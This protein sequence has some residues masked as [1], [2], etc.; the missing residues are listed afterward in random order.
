MQKRLT[1][2]KTC[3]GAAM[4]ILIADAMSGEA[5]DILSMSS[6]ALRMVASSFWGSGMEMICAARGRV[7]LSDL[8][9]T[10]GSW[11]LRDRF[12]PANRFSRRPMQ[13]TL[14]E[15]LDD[16][17]STE[18]FV[19]SQTTH[20]LSFLFHPV[21]PGE[22]CSKTENWLRPRE[23]SPAKALGSGASNRVEY[24]ARE[25]LSWLT[26]LYPSHESSTGRPKPRERP[27][28]HE[29]KRSPTA[30]TTPVFPGQAASGRLREARVRAPFDPSRR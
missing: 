9:R 21:V 11:N 4:K 6:L 25:I 24:Q 16:S 14:L 5:V 28:R 19:N 13:G 7:R 8:A 23:A 10:P 18:T 15:I 26:S 2:L 20:S 12:Y 29:P 27:P 30:R 17:T 1:L 3:K 22:A